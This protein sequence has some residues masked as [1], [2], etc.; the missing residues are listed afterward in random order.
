VLDESNSLGYLDLFLL[1]KL[2]G[3][4]GH[5]RGRIVD[6]GS[7]CVTLLNVLIMLLLL[8]HVLSTGSGH[9]PATSGALSEQADVISRGTPEAVAHPAEPGKHGQETVGGG[10]GSQGEGGL[11]TSHLVQQHELLITL[12]LCLSSH[13]CCVINLRLPSLVL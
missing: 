11:D 4:S 5:I 2:A 1:C 7:R 12:C 13:C 6:W 10:E 8:L 9:I 3:R